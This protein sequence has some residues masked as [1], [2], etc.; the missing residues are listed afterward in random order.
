MVLTNNLSKQDIYPVTLFLALAIANSTIKGIQSVS[1]LSLLQS[2]TSN[3]FFQLFFNTDMD[4]IPILRPT[5]PTKSIVANFA[6]KPAV[7]QDII[8]ELI[9]CEYYKCTLAALLK[10]N[11]KAYRKEANI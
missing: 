2:N 10:N 1:D 4:K 8:K 7:L 3:G 5:C 6:I 11:H 9:K